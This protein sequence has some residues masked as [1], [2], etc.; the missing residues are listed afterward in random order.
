[1]TLD[2]ARAA[3]GRDIRDQITNLK[4]NVDANGVS[5]HVVTCELASGRRNETGYFTVGL[6]TVN[7]VVS[8]QAENTREIKIVT[9][10]ELLEGRSPTL[11]KLDVEGHEAE[12]ITGAKQTLRRPS[13]L[14]IETEGHSGA[15]TEAIEAAGFQ[16]AWYEPFARYLSTIEHFPQSNA[17]FIRKRDEIEHRLKSAPRRKLLGKIL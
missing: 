5:D 3:F 17:L 15:V 9:L 10:D 13:L 6:D 14:A 7:H 8:A 11:L 16:R 12:V 4:R 1:M 2:E